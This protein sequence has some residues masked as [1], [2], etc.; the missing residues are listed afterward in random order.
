[1]RSGYFVKSGIPRTHLFI[2]EMAVVIL[3]FGI[4]GGIAAWTFVKADQLSEQSAQLSDG[5]LLLQSAAEAD[6]GKT[7]RE[8][9]VSET[10][11][12]RKAVPA[13]GG[14]GVSENDGYMLSVRRE[15][16]VRKAGIMVRS[17]YALQKEGKI[18]YRLEAKKYFPGAEGAL[19]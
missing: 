6:R 17:V 1:M 11:R 5:I 9:T 14:K 13:S 8:L 4:A 12:E 16:G 3:F 10:G 18:I 7:L 15:I 19:E 2:I